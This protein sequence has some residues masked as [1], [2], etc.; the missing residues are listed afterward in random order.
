MKKQ[1]LIVT[2][3]LNL[4]QL[5]QDKFKEDQTAE[6]YCAESPSQALTCIAGMVYCILM[7]DLQLPGIE[8]VEMIRILRVARKLPILALTEMLEPSEKVILFHAG[9]DAFIE[10]PV[11]VD[12]CIA[13]ANILAERCFGDG[14]GS[15]KYAPISFGSSLVIIPLSR[16]VLVDGVLL[17]LTR[18]EFDLLYCFARHPHWV[19]SWE[20]LYARVWDDSFVTGGVATVKTHIRMLRRKLG[21]G[22]IRNVWGVGYK[23]VPPDEAAGSSTMEF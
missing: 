3:D 22:F 16:D 6:L 4:S 13:Q 5:I 17:N 19:F 7:I 21:K 15:T 14:Q 1:F 12:V 8:A 9:V 10:K 11:N 2:G 20:Q 18:K 23:F